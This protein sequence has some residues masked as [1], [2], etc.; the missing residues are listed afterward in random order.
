[1]SCGTCGLQ[2]G[3]TMQPD[4]GV[5]AGAPSTASRP[6]CPDCKAFIAGTGAPCANPRCPSRRVGQLPPAEQTRYQ[7]MLGVSAA[8]GAFPGPLAGS[9]PPHEAESPAGV[10]RAQAF[11]QREPVRA[12]LLHSPAPYTLADDAVLLAG[13][14]PQADQFA[15]VRSY[16]PRT[17]VVDLLY[18]D[19]S[20]R[21]RVEHVLPALPEDLATAFRGEVNRQQSLGLAEAG[22]PLSLH[23]VRCGALV[24]NPTACLQCEARDAAWS[25]VA[26]L[27]ETFWTQPAEDEADLRTK[28]GQAIHA[29]SGVPLAITADGQATVAGQQALALS[30]AQRDRVARVVGQAVGPQGFSCDDTVGVWGR[31][32]GTAMSQAL[33]R[34]F[35]AEDVVWWVHAD[36]SLLF[37]GRNGEAVLLLRQDIRIEEYVRWPSTPP[38]HQDW[39]YPTAQ[40]AADQMG[41][42]GAHIR[43]AQHHCP[44]CGGYATIAGQPHTCPLAVP[45]DRIRA[46]VGTLQQ[47]IPVGRVRNWREVQRTLEHGLVLGLVDLPAQAAI[48]SAALRAAAHPEARGC[49]DVAHGIADLWPGREP[50]FYRLVAEVVHASWREPAAGA[51]PPEEE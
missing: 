50:H 2:A 29:L 22:L 35:S 38:L 5:P 4:T 41:R 17:I 39:V 27:P 51:R 36:E 20:S 44:L 8:Q 11:L 48:W 25:P 42:R 14:G 16:R 43:P 40:E 47:E 49:V 45:Q 46:L 31:L 13:R 7:A 37:S 24:T 3:E 10:A 1:M 33:L 21:R 6:R 34:H 15:L 12:L 30:P 23:C 26:D 32:Q 28:V 19:G 9:Q 18:E